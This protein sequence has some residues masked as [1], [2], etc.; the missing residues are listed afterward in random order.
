MKLTD[1]SHRYVEEQSEG[2]NWSSCMSINHSNPSYRQKNLPGD[3][4][5]FKDNVLFMWVIGG[6]KSITGVG[7]EA[8]AKL[9]VVTEQ[10]VAERLLWLAY[11][12]H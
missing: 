11:G 5:H 6:P 4:I 3:L 10:Q 8:R 2:N 7:F 9:R 1:Y 12:E